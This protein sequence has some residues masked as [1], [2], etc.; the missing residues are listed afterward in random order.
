[1]SGHASV[2]LGLE[3]IEIVCISFSAGG[4]NNLSP[5]GKKAKALIRLQRKKKDTNLKAIRIG[6]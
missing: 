6:Y 1:M 5:G 3:E 4:E 2:S